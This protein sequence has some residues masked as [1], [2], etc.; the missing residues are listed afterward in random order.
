MYLGSLHQWVVKTLP[1][2]LQQYTNASDP[3]TTIGPPTADPLIS[4]TPQ[5]FWSALDH[6]G[7]LL[8][9]DKLAK[10]YET[11]SREDATEIKELV[12]HQLPWGRG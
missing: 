12:V 11:S 6:S 8:T 4:D 9:V 5:T 10:K 2:L 3:P 1:P 7:I